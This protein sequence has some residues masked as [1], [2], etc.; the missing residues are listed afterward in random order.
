[1]ARESDQT[2]IGRVRTPRVH[3]TYEV[4]TEGEE[5]QREIP[6]VL[7][8][9]A[10]LSGNPEQPLP[11]LADRPF[12]EIDRDTIDSVMAKQKPRLL[13][14]VPDR[15]TDAADGPRLLDFA[16][17]FEKMADFHPEAIAMKVEPLRKLLE[18][19]KKLSSLQ[20]RLFGNSDLEKAIQDAITE[21][22]QGVAEIQ[23]QTAPVGGANG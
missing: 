4:E 8:I 21:V 22:M 18:L 14:S 2:R 1:M 19:R 10:D 9:L 17:T 6:F 3:I 16:L 23:K 7:G 20:D 13:M 5:R 11:E 15:L 12:V